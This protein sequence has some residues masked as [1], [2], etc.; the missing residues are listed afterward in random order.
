M[1]GYFFYVYLRSNY[2]LLK[3]K[4]EDLKKMCDGHEPLLEALT[5]F[6][7]SDIVL[8]EGKWDY[9]LNYGS[10]YECEDED[11]ELDGFQPCA[12]KY[13]DE[14]G[15]VIYEECDE[16][17]DELQGTAIGDYRI[18]FDLMIRT[19]YLFKNNMMC[20]GVVEGFF[21]FDSYQLVDG[22]LE[23]NENYCKSFL[24]SLQK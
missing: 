14:D 11:D 21:D 22:E 6:S 4:I 16:A 13:V 10:E 15:D 17:F 23:R 3:M 19:I 2:K 18:F 12:I 20:D 24:D 9:E 8:H 5:Y 1:V 7:D